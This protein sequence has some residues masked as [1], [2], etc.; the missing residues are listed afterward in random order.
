M[1]AETRD[2]G[3]SQGAQS[4]E[5]ICRAGGDGELAIGRW[6]D[7]VA[8]EK[9][10]FND[11][12]VFESGGSARKQARGESKAKAESLTGTPCPTRGCDESPMGG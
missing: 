9:E 5:E 11:I 12:D 7:K 6:R 10:A 1:E 3:E 8:N 4:G 2:D